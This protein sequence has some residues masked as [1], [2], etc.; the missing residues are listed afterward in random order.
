MEKK[1]EVSEDSNEAATAQAAS[2]DDDDEVGIGGGG[3]GG[4]GLRRKLRETTKNSKVDFH[5]YFRQV[6]NLENLEVRKYLS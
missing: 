5:L 2:D 6:A 3:G 4:G 1:V